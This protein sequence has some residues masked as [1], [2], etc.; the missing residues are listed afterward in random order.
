MGKRCPGSY[1]AEQT[2]SPE[3]AAISDNGTGE[4]PECNVASQTA[5]LHD[6]FTFEMVTML[7]N[8]LCDRQ[9]R[10]IKRRRQNLQSWSVR[11]H[12]A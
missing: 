5:A 2:K 10:L 12:T 8:N 7:A 3:V 6:A 4:A 9:E 1:A 11:S